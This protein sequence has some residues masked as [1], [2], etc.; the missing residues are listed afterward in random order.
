MM[1]DAQNQKIKLM[2][3]QT[4]DREHGQLDYAESIFL[5]TDH[6]GLNKFW[7]PKDKNFESFLSEFLEAFDHIGTE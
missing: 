2:F 3:G 7:S 5:N 4:V 6:R 1:L